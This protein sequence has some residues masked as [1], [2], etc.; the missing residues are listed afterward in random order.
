MATRQICEIQ[1]ARS[2]SRNYL[3]REIFKN[4]ACTDFRIKAMG[5][6]VKSSIR[7]RIFFFFD[8]SYA[9]MGLIYSCVSLEDGRTR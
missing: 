3:S 7:E 1:A 9:Y 4:T 6:N 5:L 8:E 2:R